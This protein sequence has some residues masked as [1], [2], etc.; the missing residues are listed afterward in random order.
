[1]LAPLVHRGR[2]ELQH[3]KEKTKPDQKSLNPQ[4]PHPNRASITLHSH[5]LNTSTF[6]LTAAQPCYRRLS[7]RLTSA[8]SSSDSSSPVLLCP[9]C[10][11][12]VFRLCPSPFCRRPPLVFPASC[13]FETT[14][15]GFAVEAFGNLTMDVVVEELELI[16]DEKQQVE[17]VSNKRNK[18]SCTSAMPHLVNC[19]G[20]RQVVV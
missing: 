5:P 15:T 6:T 18:L 8:A 20:F 16:D 4:F 11:G 14:S 9:R 19:N 3:A 12:V 1:M 17:K 10:R 2:A 13:L 7:Y